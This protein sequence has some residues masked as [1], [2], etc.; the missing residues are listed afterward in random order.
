MARYGRYDYGFPEYIPVYEKKRRNQQGVEKLRKKDSAI[1]PVIIGGRKIAS[2][3]WGESWNANLERYADYSNRIGRG[4][5]Y[6]R[7]GAVL[8]LR[9]SPG[10]AVALVQGS[11]TRPYQVTVK[12][13]PLVKKVWKELRGTALTQLDSLADLLAGK[14]PEALRE[15]F[16]EI[17]GGLFPTP[18]EIEFDCSCPDWASMCKH[19]AATLY[20]IGSRLD[21]QPEMLFALRQVEME[22]L[23]AK[24]IDATAEQWLQ[25]AEGAGGDDVLADSDVAGVFGIEFAE[26]GAID[27][28]SPEEAL[29]DIPARAKSQTK[30]KKSGKARQDKL[31]KV[32]KSTGKGRAKTGKSSAKTKARDVPAKA[33]VKSNPKPQAAPPAAR[34]RRQPVGSMVDQLAAVAPRG[35]QGFELSDLRRK[36]PGWSTSQVSNTLQR[37]IREGVIERVSFGHYRYPKN[38][39]K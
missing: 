17:D 5:S 12:I 25:K 15:A 18:K 37:A 19:V 7:H 38:S 33:K 32:G 34:R 23:I 10:Q 36:L 3:W 35:R 9:I 21:S 28:D 2:T 22:E 6:V 13:R 26:D 11:R 4:R 29:Q 20:G 16:F 24:T 1:Q 39:A 27:Y 8:D 30:R 14:F 31:P